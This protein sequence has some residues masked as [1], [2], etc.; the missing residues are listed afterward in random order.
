MDTTLIHNTNPDYPDL[1]RVT[2][3]IYFVGNDR[4]EASKGL[5]FDDDDIARDFAADNGY[6]NIYAVQVFGF[7]ANFELV[8]TLS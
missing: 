1:S 4:D 3:T 5:P 2:T 6:K 8:D 7:V